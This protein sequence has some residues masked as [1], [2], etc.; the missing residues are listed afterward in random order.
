LIKKLFLTLLLIF[1]LALGS[2][3]YLSHRS[4]NIV[5]ITI[6]TL[7]ADHLSCYNPKALP[8]PNIDRIA[9]NGVLFRNAYSTIP[10]TLPAHTAMFTSREPYEAKVFNNT[11]IFDHKIPML[12]DILEYEGYHTAAFISLGVLKGTNGL[13][14]G[15]NVYDD[16]FDKYHGRYYRFASEMNAV[17]LPWLEEQ[18]KKRFFAWIHYSDPHEPY[19]TQ[20]AK[21]DTE[22]VVQNSPYG[23]Y[24]FGKRE[25]VGLNFTAQPGVNRV[26]LFALDPNTGNRIMEGDSHRYIATNIFITPPEGITVEFGSDWQDAHLQ[27]IGRVHGFNGKSILNVVNSNEK[28]VKVL[29]RF[30]T[31]V[32][33]QDLNVVLRNYAAEVQHVDQAIGEL[34]AKLQSLEI[35]QKTII[36]L[37]A[38]HGEGLKD[39]GILGHVSAL[40]NE[41]T[42]VPLIIDYPRLGYKN[43]TVD[44]LVNHLDLMP[45]ILDLLH[46]R[47][48]KTM[49]GHSLKQYISWSPIDRMIADK[50]IRK[51]SLIST[52]APEAR[53]NTFAIVKGNF[54]LIHSPKRERRL[55]ELYDLARDPREKRNLSRRDAGLF[56]STQVNEMRGALEEFRKGA[57]KAHS[58]RKKPELDPEQMEMLESLGYVQGDSD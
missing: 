2:L 11:D 1:L 44:D 51:Q 15:F 29:V 56:Q 57:E 16:D 26:E 4:Y 47:N 5:F 36:I 19:I 35:D 53:A 28:P 23:K 39:H 42:H 25:D 8:T 3:I 33:D 13:G 32:Y 43:R 45:T 58:D 9:R 17:A 41:I 46:K 38:D 18:R 27:N 55:W 54:K 12:T 49:H 21:P 52:F 7:R 50:T 22:I 6:D 31:G 10:I 24:V 14:S 34:L 37:T 20:D 48:R 30:M 40:Y